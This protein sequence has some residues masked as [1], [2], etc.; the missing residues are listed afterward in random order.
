[1][2]FNADSAEIDNAGRGSTAELLYGKSL[3]DC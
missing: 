1:M 3:A 2:Q